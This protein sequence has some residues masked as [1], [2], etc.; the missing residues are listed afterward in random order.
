LRKKNNWSQEELA[1][2]LGI[3]RQSVSKWESGT[4]IPDMDKVIALS[5]LFSVSTDYLLKDELGEETPSET[6]GYDAFEG[7]RVTLAEA[8][9]FLEQTKVYAQKISFAV[10]L[11]IFS[12]VCVVFLAS[13]SQLGVMNENLAAGIGILVLLTIVAAG[14]AIVVINSTYYG[15]YDYLETE[16]F[17]TEY[18]VD[19]IVQKGREAFM[20]IYTKG[21]AIGIALCIVCALPV[22]FIGA[23]DAEEWT[24][25]GV[26]VLLLLVGLG[27]NQIVNVSI[28]LSGYQKLLQEGD[29][30][31]DEKDFARRIR[32]FPP[33]YW[34]V[35]TAVFLAVS[36]YKES[37][38]SSWIIWPVAALFFAAL[39]GILHMVLKNNVK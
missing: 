10:M 11:F 26:A 38:E 28:I 39:R 37:W 13:L 3:S 30:T 4:S 14:V 36:L 7:R 12:P 24:G 35:V 31:G 23:I 17:I 25:I 2:Q 27:V 1:G 20:P 29:Y 32:Y 6:K 8:N 9:T 18:G 33:A 22:I 15:K 19:G 16:R 21:L 5:N 34:C